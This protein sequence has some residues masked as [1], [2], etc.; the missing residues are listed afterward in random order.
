MRTRG[1]T[2]VEMLLS[3]TLLL[4]IMGLVVAGFRYG[5]LAF[6]RATVQQ[7]AAGDL[8]RIATSLKRDLRRTHAR[9]VSI[10]SRDHPS[11]APRDGLCL[12]TLQ[13][14]NDPASFD[15]INGLPKWDRYVIYYATSD[16]KLIRSRLDPSSPDFSPVPFPAYSEAYLSDDPSLN[17]SQQTG[18]VLLSEQVEDFECELAGNSVQARIRIRGEGGRT[19][20]VVE[21]ILDVLAENT[22]PRD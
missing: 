19:E 8:A 6:Q 21:A 7:G 22:W 2:L 17:P 20:R 16:G 15:G 3:T 5:F 9:T 12:G 4:L 11:G 10:I 13:D 1:I 18:Y 14:W